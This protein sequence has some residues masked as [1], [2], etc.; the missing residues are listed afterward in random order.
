MLDIGSGPS[1]VGAS[2]ASV[3]RMVVAI[4]VSAAMLTGL[5]NESANVYPLAS[6]AE[7]LAVRNECA[8][9]A[10]VANAFHWFDAD[11]AV[12]E[13]A[14]V[15]RRSAVLAVVWY[16]PQGHLYDQLVEAAS[17]WRDITPQVTASSERFLHNEWQAAI[18]QSPHFGTIRD[19]RIT[20][21]AVMSRDQ[22]RGWVQSW[23]HISM[24]EGDQLG[25]AMKSVD[26]VL[27]EADG[28]L[29]IPHTL[30]LHWSARR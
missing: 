24:L 14:R 4:D 17:P 29:V 6:R 12:A 7:K 9:A 28:S 15:L 16:R 19:R 23:S 1:Q 20:T 11:L 21:E 2:V 10:I 3:V 26:A 5:T 13:F 22:I 27:K 30:D 8:D 25:A 18:D